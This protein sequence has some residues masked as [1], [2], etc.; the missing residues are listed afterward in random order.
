MFLGPGCSRGPR[1]L[2]FYEGVYHN[3]N[4]LKGGPGR[5]G[6][7]GGDGVGGR[8]LG[9][10]LGRLGFLPR[11]EK[12]ACYLLKSFNILHSNIFF[13]ILLNVRFTEQQLKVFLVCN[14]GI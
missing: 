1:Y 9:R 2:Y 14:H 4:P 11:R 10:W 12:A 13:Y 3:P 6:G 7:L 5:Q 8:G